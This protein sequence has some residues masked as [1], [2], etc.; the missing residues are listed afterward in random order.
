MW[1]MCRS[2]K[3]SH[4]RLLNS[5]NVPEI[6][7]PFEGKGQDIGKN[8]SWRAATNQHCHGL[9]GTE[10]EQFSQ[11]EGSEGHHPK[12]SQYG[13]HYSFGLH[14]VALYLGDLHCAA[15]S[16]HSDTK[17]ENAKQVSS[18][19]QSSRNCP[20]VWGGDVGEIVL[21]PLIHIMKKMGSPVEE[22]LHFSCLLCECF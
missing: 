7:I 17:D 8:P 2:L 3:A 20:A 22:E 4:H 18:L 1:H 13:Y 5:R 12:L 14:D 19:I 10:L 9:I 11:R 15:Q 21:A 6:H 16:N